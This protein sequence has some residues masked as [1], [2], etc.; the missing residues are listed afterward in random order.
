MNRQQKFLNTLLKEI[1]EICV[2]ND[3]T[4]YIAGGTLIGALRHEGFLPW[5]DDADVFMTN[6]E[7]EKFKKACQTD[8]PPN[9]ALRTP[10]DLT[11]RNA[12]PRY[13]STDTTSYHSYQILDRDDAAGEVI[14]VF[15][16]YPI[17]GKNIKETIKNYTYDTMLLSELI[18]YSAVFGRR[19][20]VAKEDFQ[21]I[22]DLRNAK[23][24]KAA[25]EYLEERLDSYVDPDGEYY[26]MRWCGIPL[27]YEK[28]WFDE[29]EL[30]KYEDFEVMAPTTSNMY[31]TAHYG[32][33]WCYLPPAAEE[34]VHNTTGSLDFS[35]KEALTYL[36][37]DSFDFEKIINDQYE[38]KL[39]VLEA[40]KRNHALSNHSQGIRG[41]LA[42]LEL[43]HAIGKDA[44]G[45]KKALEA[46]NGK[47]LAPFYDKYFQWQLSRPTIG[48]DDW[49]GAWRWFNPFLGK[50]D[51]PLFQG[52]IE[53]LMW[54]ERIGMA[55]RLLFIK[56]EYYGG[57]DEKLTAIKNDIL[58]FRKAVNLFQAKKLDEGEQLIDELLEK[59][60]DLPGFT[61]LKVCYLD[62]R[63]RTNKD[64][65]ARS[66]LVNLIERCLA[67]TPD[68]GFYLKYQADELARKGNQEEALELYH[69]AAELTYNG[70]TLLDIKRKTGYVPT[71][72]RG[73]GEKKP[74]P[75]RINTSDVLEG[76]TQRLD[77]N[78]RPK[79]NDIQLALFDLLTE[80]TAFLDKEGLYYV[81]DNA[82]CRDLFGFGMLPK[83]AGTYTIYMKAADL[84]EF[85]QKFEENPWKDRALE[86]MGTN[87][88]LDS[89]HVLFVNTA[90][91]WFNL[92]RGKAVKLPGLR[93]TIK[94][95]E[96]PGSVSKVDALLGIGWSRT[97]Y[98]S[99]K[100]K[101]TKKEKL[102]ETVVKAF[103]R[104]SARK[105]L[106]RHL[107]KS[108]F[109]AA[110]GSS[111]QYLVRNDTRKANVFAS[112]LV[113][114]TTMRSF[115]GVPFRTVS[116]LEGFEKELPFFLSQG[117]PGS[118]NASGDIYAST[119]VGFEEFLSRANI[120]DSLLEERMRVFKDE[121]HDRAV[122]KG[123]KDCFKQTAAAIGLKQL[124]FDLEPRM[125]EL[126]KLEQAG[127]YEDLYHI[128][129]DYRTLAIKHPNCPHLAFDPELFGILVR[130]LRTINTRECR[131]ILSKNKNSIE[132]WEQASK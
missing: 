93:V 99:N 12:L 109:K 92:K 113:N 32:D 94:L 69:R 127:K 86:H 103:G 43:E 10:D 20:E 111:E 3:I 45:F 120:P 117:I 126:K 84:R 46:H 58:A 112:D 97:C 37:E 51:E 77:S 80:L 74:L 5:D 59:Y 35:Y 78:G 18:N 71:H 27:V 4:Y 85:V 119:S 79:G 108:R 34:G 24:E 121:A 124:E 29:V 2:K 61:K 54:T 47:A 95:L 116:N 104:G 110:E 40:T 91:T 123:F 14:D 8:L 106:G 82:L 42:K 1:H 122:H 118:I 107:L 44:D 36:D 66:S 98:K 60:P 100:K 130:T 129:L 49:S 88:D 83:N 101:P 13:V 22:L 55:G 125:E 128:L 38:R 41:T 31:L 76:A 7:F 132:A 30:V 56:E 87:C 65:S 23:G 81:L 102:C 28:Q 72:Q 53:A 105:A 50:L 73:R 75:N 89:Q 16:L 15:V 114:N 26:I 21:A 90:S 17:S 25:R 70:I 131:T 67:Q 33:E 11:Y 19:Y 6:T 57:L 39:S 63:H 9:R 52:A 62:R 68:D 64:E 48:R 96:A 115:A